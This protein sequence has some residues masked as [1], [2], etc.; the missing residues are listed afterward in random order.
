[1]PVS[2]P[3]IRTLLLYLT[4]IFLLTACSSGS[5]ESSDNVFGDPIIHGSGP[6]AGGDAFDVAAPTANILFPP[7]SALTGADSIVVTGTSTDATTIASITVNGVRATS[8]DGFLTWRVRVPLSSGTNTLE[9]TSADVLGNRDPA[10][11]STVVIN[12]ATFAVPQSIALD[13]ANNRLVLVDSS[14]GA[15]FTVDL[16][17]DQRTIVSS[18]DIGGGPPLIFPVGVAVDETTSRAY[19][20][21]GGSDGV[22][23]ALVEVDLATG[24]RSILSNS[25]NG[26]GPDF[27]FPD[28]VALDL[29][30]NRNRA[31]VVDVGS[32]TVYAVDLNSGD[33][34]P[35]AEFEPGNN[36]IFPI[37]IT[38]DSDTDRALVTV[39][40]V[41]SGDS[42]V[43]AIDL[44]AD[45]DSVLSAVGSS[46]VALSVAGGITFDSI[47]DQIIV[48][49]SSLNALVRI[50]SSGNRTIF[51]SASA[52]SGDDFA[53]P[54]A[55]VADDTGRS[56]VVDTTLS[57]VFEVDNGTGDRSAL[58]AAS[59][60]S[61]PVFA[62]PFSIDID[63]ST[64]EALVTDTNNNALYGVRIID[65]A[66]RIISDASTGTG[67]L[68]IFPSS[69]AVQTPGNSAIVLDST[70]PAVV[71]IDLISGDRTIISD[72]GNGG[73]D[74]FVSP[75]GAALD[76]ANNRL[77]VTNPDLNDDNDFLLD[78]DL[79]NGG[80]SVLSRGDITSP[81]AAPAIGGG[82]AFS[83][84]QSIAVDSANQIGYVV[85]TIL[86]SLLAVDLNNGNRSTGPAGGADFPRVTNRGS[87]SSGLIP[88]QDVAL[89]PNEAIVTDG[90][91]RSVYGFNTTTGARRVITD[92]ATGLGPELQRPASV[93]FDP[94]TGTLFIVDGALAAVMA[95]E[96]VSGDRVIVSR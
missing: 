7:P 24:N 56:F 91:E 94:A 39:R 76:S 49:D 21:D 45:T 44:L 27:L 77:L 5:K 80:R 43:V 90:D 87:F 51:S 25:S 34:T 82:P 35:V 53:S 50:D 58:S 71:S 18:D 85:D 54:V 72:S 73:G 36:N 95:I 59:I 92:I 6:D 93:A 79:A 47:S 81:V 60:G 63:R 37:A 83:L 41:S 52:G 74:A 84:P 3:L 70:A 19:V 78:V 96:P 48:S 57:T 75:L 10:A 11:A 30:G 89:T 8:D 1:M 61:G 31:L 40:N 4:V 26:G 67:N 23:P 14:L 86:D 29:G 69:V 42:S 13:P 32:D 20:V 15:V 33:R 12:N 46:G 38:V 88:F 66:R 62:G 65:G 17:S 28:T 55:L 9:V 2:Q 16:N 64:N 22:E 68:L